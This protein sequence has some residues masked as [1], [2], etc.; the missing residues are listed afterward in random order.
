MGAVELKAVMEPCVE[1]TDREGRTIT[2]GHDVVL[3]A[4]VEILRAHGT[5]LV[6]PGYGDIN[7]NVA[8]DGVWARGKTL[9]EALENLRESLRKAE[10]A[11]KG[12]SDA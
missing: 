6:W 5:P 12:G 2:L 1:F 7:I 8:K 9:P 10:L 4:A 11:R 3:N